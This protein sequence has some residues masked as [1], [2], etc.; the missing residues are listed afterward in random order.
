M[1][2]DIYRQEWYLELK[3]DSVAEKFQES[4]RKDIRCFG[5]ITCMHKVGVHIMG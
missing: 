2:V 3:I 1:G 5:Q 4:Q